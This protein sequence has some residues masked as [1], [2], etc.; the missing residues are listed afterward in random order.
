VDASA[1]TRALTPDDQP[2]GLV[3]ADADGL[4]V[5][6]N[7]PAQHLTGVR[8]DDAIGK[9]LYDVLPFEDI[10]GRLWWSCA[11]PWGG[12]STRTGHP[13]RLLELPGGRQLLVT[14]KYVRNSPAGPVQNVVIALRD[15]RA[16]LRIDR[17]HAD[18]LAEAAHEIRTPLTSLKGFAAVL[19]RR[20]D[21]FT[22]GQRL[23]M[24]QTIGA[25]ADRLARLVSTILDIARIDAGR[26]TMRPRPL[27]LAKA[28][29][30]QIDLMVSAGHEPSTFVVDVRGP[31][32]ETWA[33]PD[34]MEQVLTNLLENA[35]RHGA[36]TVTIVVQPARH[37]GGEATA[38]EVSDQGAGL[39]EGAGA[40]VFGKFWSGGSNAGTGLG[41]YVVKAII[42]AHGGTV[43][44]ANVPDGGAVFRF[45]LPAGAQQLP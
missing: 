34:Q 37:E 15:T 29:R 11:D 13:E 31:L 19:A 41:L 21:R 45:V 43:E 27:D 38:V 20:W 16:R 33:D 3:I 22:D 30:K 44:A 7:V 23:L 40:R 6:F 39:P 2:D 24:V 14:A 18:L 25:D 8:S 42:E 12:L 26:F 9:A 36:G 4:V 5:L 10:D 32:P 17:D 1:T 28:T 35:V